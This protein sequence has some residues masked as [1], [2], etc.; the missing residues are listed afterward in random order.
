MRENLR[1]AVCVGCLSVA[2]ILVINTECGIGSI[3]PINS[4]SSLLTLGAS[5]LYGPPVDEAP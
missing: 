4:I 5:G 3:L 1:V 2:N